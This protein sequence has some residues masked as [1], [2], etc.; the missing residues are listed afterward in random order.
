[1]RHNSSAATTEQ[2]VDLGIRARARGAAAFPALERRGNLLLGAFRPRR[3]AKIKSNLD[4]CYEA[5]PRLAERRK[6]LAGS[7]SGGEQQMLALV[8]ALMLDPKI[9]LVDEPSVGARARSSSAAPS[10]RSR[11]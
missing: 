7:M 2:I 5:F 10:I 11:N 8:R 3:R 4:F 6:Q 9:L 1:V